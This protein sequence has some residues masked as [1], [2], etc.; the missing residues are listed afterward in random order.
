MT[1]Y[2]NAI[3]GVALAAGDR[4]TSPGDINYLGGTTTVL[5]KKFIPIKSLLW[6]VRPE[7]K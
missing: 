1:L 5:M 7:E 2:A 4:N 6:V 3:G